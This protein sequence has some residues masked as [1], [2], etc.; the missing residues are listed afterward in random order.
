[1]EE[2]ILSELL[3]AR[4]AASVDEKNSK[5]GSLAP[6]DTEMEL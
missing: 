1:M 4:R 6:E 2:R 3:N 5:C